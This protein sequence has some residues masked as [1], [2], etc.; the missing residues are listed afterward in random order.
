MPPPKIY[1]LSQLACHG[2]KEFGK[3]NVDK[4]SETYFVNLDLFGVD[5]D[6]NGSTSYLWFVPATWGPYWICD[7]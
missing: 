7:V 6:D 2:T 3:G 5:N 4:P 1:E